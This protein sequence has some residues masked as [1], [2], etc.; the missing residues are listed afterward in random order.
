MLWVRVTVNLGPVSLPAP[1]RAGIFFSRSARGCPKLPELLPTATARAT[2]C[3]M[4]VKLT[5][6]DMPGRAFAVRVCLFAFKGESGWID[7]RIASYDAF[8]AQKAAGAY[9]LGSVPV[10]TVGDKTFVQSEAIT[11]WAA[12]GAGLYPAD[13]DAALECDMVA[14]SF[15]EI[16]SKCPQDDEAA[17]KK[18]KWEEYAA[19][20]MMNAMTFL[21]KL[22]ASTPGAF[23]SADMTMADLFLYMVVD[24]IKAG[25][26]DHVD[27]SYVEQFPTLCAAFEAVKGHDVVTR[28]LACY[29]N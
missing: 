20:W 6:F 2:D 19:G 11:R 9:P 16:L 14:T 27:P 26:F 1:S 13:A 25:Q 12:K 21:E 23:L 10:L 29:P 8:Q 24:M 28:Y 22:Y 7:D 5:Y 4:A 15:M 3:S 18:K 17:V